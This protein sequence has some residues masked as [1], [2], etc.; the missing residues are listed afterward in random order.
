MLHHCIVP[1]CHNH[2]GMQGLLFY[3]LPLRNPVLLKEWLIK[4]RRENTPLNEHFRVCSTHFTGGKKTRKF[5]VPVIFAWTKLPHPS[6]R[7]QQPERP[8]EQGSGAEVIAT[9]GRALQQLNESVLQ[10]EVNSILEE[11]DDQQP[12]GHED[13]MKEQMVVEYDENFSP[14]Y[15][16]QCNNT[17]EK[18]DVACN[19]CFF[20]NEDV[21]IQDV[22]STL[23]A[24]RLTH[25]L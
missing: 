15:E 2:S 21:G 5:D 19:I 8:I 18:V 6:K 1:L 9:Q 24:D 10:S 16:V 7:R 22:A 12:K 4:I 13:S 20:L 14:G 3:R 11:I 25:R 23:E 17:L